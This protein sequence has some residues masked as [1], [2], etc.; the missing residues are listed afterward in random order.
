MKH[1][2]F[3]L[4]LAASGAAAEHNITVLA[5]HPRVDSGDRYET[6]ELIAFREDLRLINELG[7]E[8]VPLAWVAEWISGGRD[9]PE[10]SVAITF[11]DGA[12]ATLAFLEALNDFY[13]EFKPQQ[14]YLHA[15]TFVIASPS[16]RA[17]IGG[18]QDLTDSWWRHAEV[19]PL[20]SIENHSWDH[21]HPWVQTKCDD[22]SPDEHG[23]SDVNDYAEA[24]CE[25]ALASTLIQGITGRRPAFLAYPYG[26]SSDYLRE[27]YMPK[28]ASEHGISA[29][30]STAGEKVSADSNIW[31][32]P[33][34]VHRRHWEHKSELAEILG[35]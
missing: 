10:K 28:F 33:R 32:V 2:L 8:I 16:A 21:N 35:D 22:L 30:F 19:S 25:V 27:E 1:I 15:T 17:D 23:F 11:D 26:E 13:V 34:F 20:M 14:P 24:T 9:I 6:N 18:G 12:N 7:F 4:L 5:Y 29:A 3:V 31:N